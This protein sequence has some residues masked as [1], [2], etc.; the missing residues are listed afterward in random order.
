VLSP[1]DLV[2]EREMREASEAQAAA[3][4]LKRRPQ[5][6]AARRSGGQ[7]QARRQ[8]GKDKEIQEGPGRP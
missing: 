3:K 7:E 1:S 8:P 2:D 5:V 6:E 4:E